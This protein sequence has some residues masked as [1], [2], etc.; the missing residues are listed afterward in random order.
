MTLT[1]FSN[2]LNHHQLPFC[3]EMIKLLGDGFKFVAT[4]SIPKD[5]LNMGYEDMNKTYNFVIRSYE[6]RNEYEKALKLSL[7]SDVIITG[8]A[9]E[10]FTAQ[11]M[12]KNKL[13]FRYSERVYKK[14]RWRAVSPRGLKNMLLKHTR[15]RD[16]NLY[17]LCA[18]AYTAGDFSLVGAYK[19]KC[20]KWGYFP[21]IKEY[22]IEKLIQR[23]KKNEKI[24]ILWCGRM[25]KWKHPE[26]A[27]YLAQKLKKDGFDFLMTIIGE[28]EK[29]AEL[30]NFVK[31]EKLSNEVKILNFMSPEEVRVYMEKSN[32]Y[33]F[34]SDY[35][36]GWGAVL[37]EAL[38]SGCAVVA[39]N[40]IGSVPFLL[41][42]NKNGMIYKNNS[43]N[44]LYNNVKILLK[45][46]KLRENI[47]RNGYKTMI[48]E[49][50]AKISAKRL[51]ELSKS[52]LKKEKA[53]FDK[54]PCSIIEKKY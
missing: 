25:L 37:N 15:Y 40:A 54:G 47:S 26:K 19:D 34:T 43:F 16:K 20:Y 18:S 12:E 30:E 8:S 48:E 44:D 35:N 46:V 32:I 31:N 27:V 28:G 50:N 24:S 21:E 49:W 41:D 36:E 4:E 22:D 1:F 38:N 45:D 53:V 2:F 9:P 14:G 6:N 52:L 51:I 39:S 33:I 23:K 11:R 7:E 29:R 42:H 5:R 10:I 13:T 17:M 3:L